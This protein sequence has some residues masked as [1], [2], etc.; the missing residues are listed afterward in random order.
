MNAALRRV[1][2]HR[3]QVFVH[4]RFAA[5]K[6]QVADVIFDG[7]VDDIPRFLQRDAAALLGIKPVHGEAA[8][9]ALGIAD[10]R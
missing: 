9:I 2:R 1:T 10:V 4:Q 5:D 7:D 8:E 3:A 6:Q